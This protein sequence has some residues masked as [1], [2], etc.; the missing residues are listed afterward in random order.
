MIISRVYFFVQLDNEI[1]R[2][3]KLKSIRLQ[4]A[5]KRMILSV[6]AEQQV[7]GISFISL[8]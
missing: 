5:K 6:Q 1:H 8:T 4:K 3:L 2:Q 7:F